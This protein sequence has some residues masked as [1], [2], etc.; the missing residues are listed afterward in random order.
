MASIRHLRGIIITFLFLALILP[1][2]ITQAQTTPLVN[3]VSA[4][5]EF[6]SNLTISA[7]LASANQSDVIYIVL[8][9]ER[10]TPRQIKLIPDSENGLFLNFNL[11][12]DPLKP[13]SRIYYWFQFEHDNGTT[14]TSPSYWF[15]YIDN[16]YQW[17]NLNSKLFEIYWVDG[18]TA[19]G[20]NIQDIAKTGLEKATQ[21]LPVAPQLPIRIY[22][23]PNTTDLKDGL[24]FTHQEWVSGH[25]SPELGVVLVSN[26]TDQSNLIDLERQIPH[27]LMHILQYQ[28]T[29]SYYKKAPA[30]VLEGLATYSESYPN[31]DFDRL[32]TKAANDQTLFSLDSLCQSFPINANDAA[33]AYAQS[34]SIVKF[35]ENQFGSQI[36]LRILEQSITGLDCGQVINSTSDLTNSQLETNW[37]EATF[38]GST[39]TN[40]PLEK[41]MI[42][43]I[44][45][46]VLL[47]V[48]FLLIREILK[49]KENPDR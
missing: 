18:D 10:Q 3:E 26:A 11:G 9:P 13:F 39:S 2:N 36:F 47:T 42:F 28:V 7:R 49:K 40:V 6:G 14:T 20:Q 4:N 29:G 5:Y 38:P 22:V 44:L 35:L 34:L 41:W 43:L 46:I 30:W 25:A 45:G 1:G 21:I 27:E 15:D 48:A 8:Q 12:H 31:P 24:S 17:K 23:Y 37:K 32:L 33:V 19:F 16:R